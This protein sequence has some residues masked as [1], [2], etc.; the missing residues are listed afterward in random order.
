MLRIDQYPDTASVES[1]DRMQICKWY[2]FLRG[3]KDP[4]E[5]SIVNRICDCFRKFDGFTPEISKAI[6]WD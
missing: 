5:E 4:S 1:A 6:G 2:R 3:P